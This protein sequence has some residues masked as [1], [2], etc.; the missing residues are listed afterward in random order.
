MIALFHQAHFLPWPG[1]IA[2]CVDSDIVVFLDEVKFKKG[3]YHNRTKIMR[4]DG[5]LWLTIPI[6]HKTINHK[7]Y[8][9]KIAEIPLFK[10]WFRQLKITYGKSKEFDEIWE[11]LQLAFNAHY[12]FLDNFNQS[13]IKWL[14]SK[15]CFKLERKV[16]KFYKS[17]LFISQPVDKTE[18]LL[19]ISNALNIHSILMGADSYNIHDIDKL[20]V[21]NIICKRHVHCTDKL[22][23]LKKNSTK[24]ISGLTF[25]HYVLIHGW[26][27]S[28]HQFR[29]D[30][31]IVTPN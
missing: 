1:Y 14:L 3:Y 12:P 22:S 17:S 29:T 5:I 15:V 28:I 8:E 18:R 21:N 6:N 31:E 11:Q 13:M 30:W 16:P 27:E 23:T 25:L 2:R 19:I 24:P 10:K 7:M 26:E 20:T 4:K 9:V